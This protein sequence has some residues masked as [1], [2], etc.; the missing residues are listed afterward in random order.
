[1]K[2]EMKSMEDN[3]FGILLNCLK[4]QNLLVVNG[5]SKPRGIQMAM[6][7]DLKPA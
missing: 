7:K 3:A 1:M 5:Y 2:D 4:D 6:S